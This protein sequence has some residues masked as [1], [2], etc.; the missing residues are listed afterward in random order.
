MACATARPWAFLVGVAL[1]VVGGIGSVLAFE[2]FAPDL[3]NPIAIRWFSLLVFGGA[4][5][6]AGAGLVLMFVR[7]ERPDGSEARA[8]QSPDGV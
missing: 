2:V 8:G 7:R 5:L 1:S 6:A 4:G 3:F